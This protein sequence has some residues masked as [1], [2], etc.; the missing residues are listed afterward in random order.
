[1]A[2]KKYTFI[3]E[4]VYR[5]EVEGEFDLDELRKI[6]TYKYLTDEEILIS[7]A[8]SEGMFNE[9]QNDYNLE[10]ENV[11]NIWSADEIIYED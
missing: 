6:N 5:A 11:R 4:K 10:E 2:K 1:M 8:Q 7:L 9:K 3:V